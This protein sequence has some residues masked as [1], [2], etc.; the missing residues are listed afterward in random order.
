MFNPHEIQ[1]W[2]EECE[3]RESKI[4]TVAVTS[5][6]RVIQIS[7]LLILIAQKLDAK[8][9]HM[10]LLVSKHF[11]RSIGPLVWKRV[12]GLDI[13]MRLIKDVK[14]EFNRS[15]VRGYSEWYDHCR[16]TLTLPSNP[17]LSRYE[18]YSPW[19]HELEIF[20][21]YDQEIKN[22][23]P[24]LTRL[25]GYSPLP[26]LQRLTTYTTLSIGGEQLM[27]FINIFISKQGKPLLIPETWFPSLKDRRL[28]DVHPE[29]VKSLWNQPTIAQKLVSAL[30]Q[31]DYSELLFRNP[32]NDLAHNRNWLGPFLAALPDLSPRL[33]DVALYIG[34]GDARKEILRDSVLWK[35][36]IEDTSREALMLLALQAALTV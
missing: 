27:A 7:E 5:T 8:K 23:E 31:T 34:D 11:F 19:I 17:D 20:A 25:D 35:Y 6:Q 15:R 33:Q 30:I 36:F 22:L 24:F 32:V 13:M 2:Y 29:D 18:I 3:G 14:V 1:I 4:A 21:G 16:W 10:L 12:P 28:Y 9:Q 26:N